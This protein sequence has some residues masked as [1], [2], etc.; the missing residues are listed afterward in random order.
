MVWPLVDFEKNS[1]AKDE[2]FFS[3]LL[4]LVVYERAEE[5]K[6]IRVLYLPVYY[7]Y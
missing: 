1:G 4:R 5:K 6:R 3:F 2:V 7:N